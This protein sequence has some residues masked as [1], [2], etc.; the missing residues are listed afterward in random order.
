MDHQDIDILDMDFVFGDVGMNEG[1]GLPLPSLSQAMKTEINQ[2]QPMLTGY[3][4]FNANL[5]GQME[6]PFAFPSP[7]MQNMA[8]AATPI[9]DM[10][11]AFSFAQVN[12]GTLPATPSNPTPNQGNHM[13]LRYQQPLRLAH[14]LH[15]YPYMPQPIQTSLPPPLSSP[16]PPSLSTPGLN[17]PAMTA[18]PTPLPRP[19]ALAGKLPVS[20]V[21]NPPPPP[22]VLPMEEV[23]KRQ[24]KRSTHIQL[25]QRRRDNIKDGFKDLEAVLPFVRPGTPRAMLLS[26]AVDYIESLKRQ[27][28]QLRESMQAG[29]SMQG[30]HE[31]EMLYVNLVSAVI[32][33]LQA[34][35][36]GGVK[37]LYKDDVVKTKTELTSPEEL[38]DLFRSAREEEIKLVVM[39]KKPHEW[40]EL[41]AAEQKA[42][43]TI[44]E[45]TQL[46]KGVAIRHHGY[47]MDEDV[48]DRGFEDEDQEF[49]EDVDPSKEDTLFNMVRTHQLA[50]AG[51]AKYRD[52]TWQRARI[53]RGLCVCNHDVQDAYQFLTSQFEWYNMVRPDKI[54]PEEIF[55]ELQQNFLYWHGHDKAGRPCLVFRV[56]RNVRMQHHNGREAS[57][58]T[59]IYRLNEFEDKWASSPETKF[60]IIYDNRGAVLNHANMSLLKRLARILQ[61]NH[62]AQIHQLYVI[63]TNYIFRYSFGTLR[64]V[65]TKRF[66]SLFRILHQERWQQQLL[67][68]VSAENLEPDFGGTSVPIKD[69]HGI[70]IG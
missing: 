64:K 15:M 38:R 70:I 63:G 4:A 5:M 66:R 59:W 58:K 3:E 33:R 39:V 62:A 7:A 28:R 40:H 14:P 2:L 51:P 13:D 52:E 6:Q 60:T 55:A 65:M 44:S 21:V 37:I 45:A 57:L 22:E 36:M 54:K 48:F 69:Q 29:G 26:K 68:R 53:R 1:Q 50:G 12:S 56:G 61:V 47:Y 31:K 27:N 9:P 25:E 20:P 30:Y 24:V 16:V 18:P 34:E 67:T 35:E 32:Q 43:T 46:V 10:N 49:V 19:P 8:Q 23:E 17:T 41:M 11:L 42:S